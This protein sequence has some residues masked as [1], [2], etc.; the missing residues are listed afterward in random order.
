MQSECICKPALYQTEPAG[1]AALAQPPPT[2]WSA[3]AIP[4]YGSVG[5][6]PGKDDVPE[7]PFRPGLRDLAELE[8]AAED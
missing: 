8:R 4:S 6:A 7:N 5:Q 1:E 2:P 3:P